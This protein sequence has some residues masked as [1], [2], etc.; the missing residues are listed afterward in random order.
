[1]LQ[2]VLYGAEAALVLRRDLLEILDALG[3][4]AELH[5]EARR[6]LREALWEDL[7]NIRYLYKHAAYSDEKEYR[8]VI[9]EEK[10]A[11][12]KIQFDLRGPPDSLRR[13]HEHP[14]LVATKLFEHSGA[15]ITI[16]PDAPHKEDVRHSLDLIKRRAGLH[17][18]EIKTSQIP[19]R[20]T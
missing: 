7:G 9:P 6:V 2:R 1:M 11:M 18:L 16:G 8:I 13:Y 19:Y 17:G 14:S 4:I 20:S 12:D 15:S 3:P 5:E 10:I